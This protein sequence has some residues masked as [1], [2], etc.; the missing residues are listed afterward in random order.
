MAG[1]RLV[2]KPH[3]HHFQIQEDRRYF[4]NKYWHKFVCSD[5]SCAEYLLVEVGYFAVK[6]KI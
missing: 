2:L 1:P 3:K 4:N 5:K 6:A